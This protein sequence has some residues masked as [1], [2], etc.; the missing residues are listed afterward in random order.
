MDTTKTI[1]KSWLSFFSG[2]F[3]S[4][5]SGMGRDVSMAAVFGVTPLIAAFMVAFRFANLMRR[6][7][8]ESPLSSSFIPHFEKI[9][10]D[11][12]VAGDLFF[13]EFF[14]SLSVFLS[15]FIIVCEGLLYLLLKWGISPEITKMTMMMLPGL[16]FICLFGL[17]SSYLQCKKIYFLPGV[18]PTLFNIIWVLAVIF[19]RNDGDEAV[20]GL[21]FAVVIAFWVQWLISSPP[22]FKKIL[23]SMRWQDFLRATIFSKEV[24]AVIK[25]FALGILGVAAMQINSALD[26]VF[27]RIA[28]LDGPVYLWYAIRIEQLPVAFIGVALSVAL[29]PPLA[30][31]REESLFTAS[32]KKAFL[33]GMP[34]FA[35]LV[36]FGGNVIN[37]LFGYGKFSSN[38]VQETT[39][40]LWAYLVGLVPYIFVLLFTQ[41]FYSKKDYRTPA[42]ATAY[43]VLVNIVLN[44]IFVF[45]FHMGAISVAL[46]TSFAAIFNLLYLLKRS[47]FRLKMNGFLKISVMTFFALGCAMSVSYLL[48]DPT[49]TLVTKN[50]LGFPRGFYTKCLYLIPSGITFAVVYLVSMRKEFT[51]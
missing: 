3:L 36:F 30:R 7:F 51:N 2:T 49:F 14:F 24:R 32:L 45:G 18:A 22:V 31:K 50:P 33:Y 12:D 40:V 10:K 17:N 26:A 34:V 38:G 23:Q 11:S 25:P 5:L 39:Y 41:G 37:F 1:N 21:S 44:S 28:S 13:A 8:G 43:S 4:R 47:D 48:G 6:V 46:A 29:L 9:R 27:A 19:F 20:Y 16:L 42:F 15:F 35:A